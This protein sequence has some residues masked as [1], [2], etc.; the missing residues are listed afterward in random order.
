MSTSKELENPKGLV[1]LLAALLFL[2]TSFCLASF[3]YEVYRTYSLYHEGMVVT[4]VVD[5]IED[6]SNTDA[7]WTSYYVSFKTPDGNLHKITNH[8]NTTDNPHVYQV[9]QHV[10]VVYDPKAPDDGRIDNGRE[11]YGVL[12][13]VFFMAA[14]G[15]GLSTYFYRFILRTGGVAV[16]L[17]NATDRT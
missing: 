7:D 11:K 6:N 9:G 10:R 2:F 14:F 8:Y 5:N 13:G 1:W 12:A 4:G 3:F 17:P 16:A 15:L